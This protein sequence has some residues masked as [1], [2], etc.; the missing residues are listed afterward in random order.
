M[1]R[2]GTKGTTANSME[3]RSGCLYLPS[4]F[5]AGMLIKEKNIYIYI[6]SYL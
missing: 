4:E 6:L 3:L 1:K 5:V 2:S